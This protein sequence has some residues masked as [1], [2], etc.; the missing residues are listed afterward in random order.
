MHLNKRLTGLVLAGSLAL[1]SLP[2]P[3]IAAGESVFIVGNSGDEV[4]KIQQKL[5]ELNYLQANVTGYY[6]NETQ[7][8]IMA[9][10]RDKGL[11][12]DG[13]AGP[14]TQNA[15]LGIVFPS[16]K[17][18]QQANIVSETKGIS[19]KTAANNGGS[20]FIYG[21]S[22]PEVRVIQQGL[23]DAGYMQSNPSGYFGKDTE[24]AVMAF[25]QDK[26][27][28]PDGQVGPTTQ[29]ALLGKT[30]TA[31]K[32]AAPVAAAEKP[33]EQPAPQPAP[34]PE[35]SEMVVEATESYAV[36]TG[37]G[38]E[39]SSAPITKPSPV[40]TN[41][42]LMKKGSE[43]ESVV[44]LQTKLKE[45][46]YYTQDAVTGYYG[47]TTTSAVRDFQM[48]NGL[49][50]DGVAG[51]ATLAKLYSNTAVKNEQ[52][53]TDPA[54]SS[55]GQKTVELAKQHLGKPYLWGGNGP[56]AFD[57]SGLVCYVLKQQGVN[58]PR[59][60]SYQMSQYAA[61]K[62]VSRDNLMPGD[63][64]FFDTRTD[65]SVP[66]GHVGIYM[67]DGKMIDASSSAGKII[68]S[69]ITGPYYTARFRSAR[70]VF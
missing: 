66:I 6:G 39:L 2:M 28:K 60:S 12:A 8:A 30:L 21:H 14:A 54:T 57:C 24:A 48:K 17:G 58:I 52:T 65:G 11:I 42:N 26:G 37:E 46:G 31:T 41:P 68:I 5:K 15:L 29:Q 62:P 51:S 27:I 32:T 33:A 38:I 70:R 4:T 16:I 50:A 3:G 67:G 9:F 59:M 45:L 55:K 61:W 25:Q 64:L 34:E 40:Y 10:Q 19:T 7:N 1:A 47:N 35:A 63:L 18:L 43:G 69:P 23:K 22:Y 49:T 36:K 44:Q 56:A 13:K 53:A 20:V